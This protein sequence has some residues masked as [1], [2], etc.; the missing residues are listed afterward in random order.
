MAPLLL[1]Y[2]TFWATFS[3]LPKK[4]SRTKVAVFQTH[5]DSLI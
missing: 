1:I 3:K 2:L 4:M 5:L